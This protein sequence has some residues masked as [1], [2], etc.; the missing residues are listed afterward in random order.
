ME[1]RA[2]Q[3]GLDD[4]VPAGRGW[5]KMR[6]FGH[7]VYASRNG[8]LLWLCMRVGNLPVGVP[9]VAQGSW[10]MISVEEL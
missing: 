3:E 9:F 1:L 6:A 2:K 8:G 10:A 7:V 4:D 5:H